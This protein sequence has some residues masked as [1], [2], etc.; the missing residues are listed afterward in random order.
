M[1]IDFARIHVRGGRGGNGCMSFR[2]EKFIPKGGPDGG[3][4]GR[5]GDVIAVAS[6]EVNTLLHFRYNKQFFASK[7]QHGMGQNKTGH[8][9]QD[10]IITVPVGTE[11]YEIDE[12]NNRIAKIADLSED[13]EDVVLAHGGNGGRG[14]TNYKTSTN[15]APRKTTP[16][17]E[18]E[19]KHY[20]LVLK[21]MAD[22]GL[23]GFPN[24]GKSTL[25]S[26]LSSAHPKIADYEFTTLEPCLG[27]VKVGEY[28]TFVIADIPGIIE[29]AHDGKG[30]GLQFL[31]HIERTSVLLFLIDIDSENIVEKY[32]ILHDELHS[33]NPELDRRRKLVVLNKIDTL[34]FEKKEIIINKAKQALRKICSCEV[35]AISAVSGENLEALKFKIK[36]ILEL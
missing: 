4:G 30:L 13:N 24:A 18:G 36:D 16:G 26:H 6:A 2:R 25:I 14:N 5:G 11:I 7:G 19:E 33:Y 35:L 23:V 27:V 1:F 17:K 15:Q 20:E 9:G 12:Q 29:G 34:P 28:K 31:R 3:D 32:Q 8:D 22:V 10:I 21:L